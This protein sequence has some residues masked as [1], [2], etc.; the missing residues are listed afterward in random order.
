MHPRGRPRFFVCVDFCHKNETIEELALAFQIRADKLVK[1]NQLLYNNSAEVTKTSRF[2]AGARL[3][4]PSQI[5]FTPV[6]QQTPIQIAA[7]RGIPVETLYSC[8]PAA[9]QWYG[10]SVEL[11]SRLPLVLPRQKIAA[12][13]GSQPSVRLRP[14]S[15]TF[16]VYS[17]GGR[18]ICAIA[19]GTPLSECPT[20]RQLARQL[21]RPCSCN[22]QHRQHC[23]YNRIAVEN[24]GLHFAFHARPMAPGT[25][26]DLGPC[27]VTDP[28]YVVE[29]ANETV[30]SIAK[31]VG[32]TCSTL[33]R[34]N[35]KKLKDH[36]QFLVVGSE[37]VCP[38]RDADEQVDHD[39]APSCSELTWLGKAPEPYDEPYH[40]PSD[41]TSVPVQL[42]ITGAQ[43]N[44]PNA[45]S[46]VKLEPGA[47]NEL[48]IE[49]M[50]RQVS[51]SMREPD[52]LLEN[53]IAAD[54]VETE[55]L[56]MLQKGTTPPFLESPVK[57][58]SPGFSLLDTLGSELADELIAAQ[59]LL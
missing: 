8:N 28:V 52:G 13:A 49:T 29:R 4:I 47:T 16:S 46:V 11:P 10:E 31:T 33:L 9:L 42:G 22:S 19:A 41:K 18:R 15:D 27:P 1:V 2:K 20:L 57:P 50:L 40:K 17:Q 26:L 12:N 43:H 44:G 30:E 34:L 24:P 39:R 5:I 54:A 48:L 56:A 55:L 14:E 7:T 6:S 37:I 21:D 32:V 45:P 58:A 25:K 38:I 53:I 51:A 3:L 59:L 36:T 35:K 23:E